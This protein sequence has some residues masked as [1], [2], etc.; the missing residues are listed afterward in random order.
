VRRFAQLGHLLHPTDQVLVRR[1]N[2]SSRFQNQFSPL[3]I[4]AVS[5]STLSYTA[6]ADD[7]VTGIADR[8]L[9]PDSLQGPAWN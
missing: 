2:C 9:M 3:E 1:R 8:L 6:T 4:P 5:L 7:P